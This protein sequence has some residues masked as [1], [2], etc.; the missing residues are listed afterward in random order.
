MLRD[1]GICVVEPMC[2]IYSVFVYQTAGSKLSGLR[3]RPGIS[4]CTRQ[5]VSIAF[6]DFEYKCVSHALIRQQLTYCDCQ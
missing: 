2:R 1:V 3:E 5:T 6:G 4:V